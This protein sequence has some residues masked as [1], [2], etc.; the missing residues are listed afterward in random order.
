MPTANPRLQITVTR[1]TRD[2]L[3]RIAAVTKRPASKVVTEILDE[4][5]PALEQMART[6]EA[7]KASADSFGSNVRRRLTIAERRAYRQAAAGMELLA[8]IEREANAARSP[9]PGVGAKR[10]PQDRKP[11]PGD[12]RPSNTGVTAQKSHTTK[13]ARGRK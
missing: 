4:A 6:M 3:A 10:A 8:D 13:R 9:A 5:L 11:R 7:L 2:V 1:P 12:P